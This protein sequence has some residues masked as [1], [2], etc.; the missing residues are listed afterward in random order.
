MNKIQDW[1]TEQVA[2]WFSSIGCEQYT[3]LVMKEDL[4]GALL[5]KLKDQEW[6]D[7][8]IKNSFHRKKVMSKV[9][10]LLKNDG[11]A[12]LHMEDDSLPTETTKGNNSH[13]S[14][15]CYAIS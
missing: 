8:G 10:R 13:D 3:R 14:L 2:N 12:C 6:L 5:V 1:T 9:T 4:D 15:G 11:E 7:F